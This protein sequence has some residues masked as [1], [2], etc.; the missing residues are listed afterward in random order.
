MLKDFVEMVHRGEPA[1]KIIDQPTFKIDRQSKKIKT[2]VTRKILS[3]RVS[4]KRFI[5]PNSKCLTYAFG[6]PHW[7]QCMNGLSDEIYNSFMQ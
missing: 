2:K 5:S 4:S 3:N 7:N 6:L 1:S